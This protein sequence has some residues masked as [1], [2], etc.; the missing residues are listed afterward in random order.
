MTLSLYPE[1]VPLMNQVTFTVW[2]LV[3]LN[4][5]LSPFVSLTGEGGPKR[6]IMGDPGLGEV[7]FQ[8]QV[9]ITEPLLLSATALTFHNPGSELVFV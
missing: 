7:T 9:W 8:T 1:T 5:L 4:V 3:I 2:L 6:V